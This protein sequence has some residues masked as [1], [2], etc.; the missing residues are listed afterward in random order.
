M[1][2]PPIME[3]ISKSL[4]LVRGWLVWFLYMASPKQGDLRLSGLPSGQSASGGAR[5]RDRRVRA[6]LKADPLATVPSTI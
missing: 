6:D 2:Q 1:D 5:T 4:A 3:V